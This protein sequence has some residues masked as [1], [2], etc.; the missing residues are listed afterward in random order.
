MFVTIKLH[1]H[2]Y[3]FRFLTSYNVCKSF[4][5][6]NCTS[7]PCQ[8]LLGESFVYLCKYSCALSGLWYIFLFV[9]L[10]SKYNILVSYNVDDHSFNLSTWFKSLYLSEENSLN[11]MT[12][13]TNCV[14]FLYKQS[15]FVRNDVL[16]T[17]FETKTYGAKH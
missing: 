8:Y 17:Q 1:L 6:V 5:S 15:S 3:T 12:F 11:N 7:W 13:W 4:F 10:T 14:L 16:T 2:L 9:T